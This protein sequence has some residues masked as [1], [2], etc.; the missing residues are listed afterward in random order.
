M[1]D[2]DGG[3]SIDRSEVPE[4][5]KMVF[6]KKQPDGEVDAL[7][8]SLDEDGSG[9]ISVAEFRELERK[10]RTLLFPAFELQRKMRKNLLGAPPGRQQ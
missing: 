6:G 5:I 9:D 3:G 1:F 10:T 2:F 7:L 4:M 8:K